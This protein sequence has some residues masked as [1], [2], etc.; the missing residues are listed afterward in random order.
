MEYELVKDIEGIEF[1]I[2]DKRQGLS[3]Y[4]Q[5]RKK[6]KSIRFSA[7]LHMQMSLRASMIALMVKAPIKLGFDR[8]RAKDL[9]W[10]FSNHKINYQSQQ[11]VIDSFFGFSQALGVDE[12]IYRWD[13]PIPDSANEFALQH[14]PKNKPILVISPCS[15]MSYRNWN[16]EGYA[17]VARYAVK[18]Y[19]MQVV[20]T[21][22]PSD[23]EHEYAQAITQLCHAPVVNLVGQ[24]T[25]KQL[26][27]IFKHADVALAPDSGPA[28]LATAV[29]TPV[30]GLYATTNPDRARPYLSADY[31]VDCYPQA[32]QKV[33]NKS[34]ADVPFGLRAREA[35]TMDLISNDSVK[36]M[37]DKLM[38]D[39]NQT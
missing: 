12:K 24:T 16:A 18:R 25:L 26:L 32:I 22:G 21:G 36:S 3:G 8:Q 1:L 33:Y 39:Q 30:I 9:Q 35:G 11:H 13:I 28:H 27:A 31:V 17:D 23:I 10:L 19:A 5:L 29:G 37:L 20:I 7:L 2:F 14:L 15:S 34:V 6:L 38:L 4:L